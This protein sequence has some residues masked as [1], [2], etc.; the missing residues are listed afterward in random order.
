MFNQLKNLFKP[1]QEKSIADLLKPIGEL[2]KKPQPIEIDLPVQGN[3]QLDNKAF[4]KIPASSQCGYTSLAV[5]L[6]QFIPE[7][8]SDKFIEDIINFWEKDFITNK[9]QNRFG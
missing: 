6:S 2:E 7:S 5:L 8:K 9:K 4:P 3:Y 1:K